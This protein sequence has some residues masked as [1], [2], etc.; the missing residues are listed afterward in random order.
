M[1]KIILIGHVGKDPEIVNANNKAARFSLATS[2]TYKNKQGE[3]Q[4]DTTWHNIVIWGKMADVIDKFV[5]KGTQLMIEGKQSNRSYEK[6][7]QTRYISEV[8]CSNFEFLGAKAEKKEEP[9]VNQSP[10]ETEKLPF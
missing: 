8:V 1:N 3:K 10:E 9:Q 6:D 5:K 7:G 2:E 4:T